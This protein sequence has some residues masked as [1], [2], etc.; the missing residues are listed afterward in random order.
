MRNYRLLLDH[1][2]KVL[3]RFQHPQFL[4]AD[5]Y[6][7]GFLISL[8]FL[9]FDNEFIDDFDPWPLQLLLHRVHLSPHEGDGLSDHIIL[10]LLFF[11]DLRKQLVVHIHIDLLESN[12]LFG[13]LVQHIRSGEF[14]VR[15]K[16][17]SILS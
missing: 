13:L 5:N 8:Y 3:P 14:K 17:L 2:L 9:F 7:F 4:S 6:F 1:L 11:R 16:E 10:P 12:A 15:L